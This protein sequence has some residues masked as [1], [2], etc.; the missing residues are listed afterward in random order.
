MQWNRQKQQP[1]LQPISNSPADRTNLTLYSA[2]SVPFPIKK[3]PLSRILSVKWLCS[4]LWSYRA[5]TM[6]S[7]S[8]FNKRYR[9]TLLMIGT[10]VSLF[11]ST[12][13]FIWS[14]V[15]PSKLP[16][17]DTVNT[18]S[19]FVAL[20]VLFTFWFQSSNTCIDQWH[21]LSIASYYQAEYIQYT[22]LV[23]LVT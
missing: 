6:L 10:F 17:S 14:L 20:N 15:K 18:T 3:R 16:A 13:S 7:I 1:Q 22:T 11:L 23:L 2:H 9:W 5:W 8:L 4:I 12:Y 19:G 21:L